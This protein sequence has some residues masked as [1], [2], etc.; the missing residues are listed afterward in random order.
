MKNSYPDKQRTLAGEFSVTGKGL[1]TGLESTVI[2]HPA[3]DNSGYKI[4]RVDLPDKPLIDAHAENVLSTN[5]GTVLSVNGIQVG[6]VEHALAAL[7][8]NGIDNCFI[9]VDAPEFPI[10]DGS[11]IQ[12]VHKIIEC[13]IQ[14]QSMEREYYIPGQTIEYTD[15]LSG[16]RLILSPSDKFSIYTQISF[17]SVILDVQSANLKELS[18]FN[19]EISMCR[20]FVFVRE[21]EML[22]KNGLI[23]GG[24]LD[25]AIVIYD[26]PVS[27]S[28]FDQI[29]DM[30]KVE[31]RDATNLGYIMNKPLR[32]PNEPA[33]HK[34]LDILGDISLIGR[35]IKGMI[36]SVC[37][38]HKANNMFARAILEDMKTTA[39]TI[40]ENV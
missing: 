18:E 38:G 34:I 15:M 5:R 17:D 2:F 27:Q 14:E 7:Y 28:R 40:E 4:R 31:R 11:S 33:R 32:F 35:F 24:D 36:I 26:H 8:A 13:G 39:V 29:A 22:L 3:P 37:P 19:Q 25:N 9:D 12:Y 20:T 6:T 10:L 21:I 1:H 30:I 23:R 16:T